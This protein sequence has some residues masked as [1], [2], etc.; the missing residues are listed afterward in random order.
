MRQAVKASLCFNFI[1]KASVTIEIVSEPKADEGQKL[2]PSMWTLLLKIKME[3]VTGNTMAAD[4]SEA[5]TVVSGWPGFL[6]I[7]AR[8]SFDQ[9]P[10]TIASIDQSSVISLCW[11]CVHRMLMLPKNCTDKRRYSESS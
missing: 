8:P 7:A 10:I 1:Y 2:L 4:G 6:F 3:T 11:S 5:N 9:S